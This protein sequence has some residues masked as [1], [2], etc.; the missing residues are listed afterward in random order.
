VNISSLTRIN[1]VNAPENE[2]SRR[3]SFP[4]SDESNI[5]S[6]RG[7][8]NIPPS[9]NDTGFFRDALNSN[10]ITRTTLIVSLGD[11][12]LLNRSAGTGR[13]EEGRNTGCMGSDALGERSLRRKF[14]GN[15]P[16]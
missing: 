12:A 16:S 7:L 4:C 8:H 1:A 14:K 15:L 9:I 10:A 3:V 11:G 6:E 2:V 5:P 13:S